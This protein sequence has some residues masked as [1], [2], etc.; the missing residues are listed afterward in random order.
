MPASLV[1]TECRRNK[2]LL[3]NNCRRLPQPFS[4]KVRI[5]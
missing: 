4:L 1:V 3:P 5:I 2:K